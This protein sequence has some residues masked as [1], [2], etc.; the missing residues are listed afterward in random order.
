MPVLSSVAVMSTVSFKLAIISSVNISG[1]VK[2]GLPDA[3]DKFLS[4]FSSAS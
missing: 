2:I 3:S 4:N 1:T